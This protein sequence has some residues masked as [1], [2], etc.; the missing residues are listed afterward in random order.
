[1]L[2]QALLVLIAPAVVAQVADAVAADPELDAIAD[3]LTTVETQ[4]GTL[5][6]S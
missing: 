2:L 3:R 4:L 6:K 1:M 5:G